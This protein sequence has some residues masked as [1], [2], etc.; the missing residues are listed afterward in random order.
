MLICKGLLQVSPAVNGLWFLGVVLR[1]GLPPGINFIR[2]FSLV[3]RG[4]ISSFIVL[5]PL[6]VISFITA[7]Y[8]LYLYRSRRHGGVGSLFRRSFFLG[9]DTLRL[10]LGVL[11][12][13]VRFLIVDVFYLA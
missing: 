1:I 8:S 12:L 7:G 9:G 3:S 2:E 10:A 11:F 13:L 4:T 6:V 5:I